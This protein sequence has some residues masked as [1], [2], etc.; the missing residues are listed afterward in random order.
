MITYLTS[1]F[2]CRVFGLHPIS[3]CTRCINDDSL[4]SNNREH[5]FAKV[6]SNAYCLKN[7]ANLRAS[8]RVPRFKEEKYFVQCIYYLSS[9]SYYI[10]NEMSFSGNVSH[11]G[12]F[13]ALLATI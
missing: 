6:T 9:F 8:A 12:L 10:E 7:C 13:V 2:N 5:F 11:F 4:I 1:T 3:I